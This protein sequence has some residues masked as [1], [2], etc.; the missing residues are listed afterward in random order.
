M[1]NKGYSIG[2]TWVFGIVTLFGLGILYIVFSQVFVAHLLPTFTDL[3]LN[4]D[5]PVDT[6]N[7]ILAA[8][9]KYMS[10]FNLL[11]FILF[12]I[13]VIYMILAAFRKERESE[14]F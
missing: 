5:I 6:Q 4:S 14:L 13:V 7:E 10:F 3:T 2:F 1:N 8:Y 12:G 11:P 9:A